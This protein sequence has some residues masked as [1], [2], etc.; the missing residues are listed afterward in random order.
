MAATIS[1]YL[2]Q[3]PGDCRWAVILPGN[4][5]K[6]TALAKA[7]APLLPP[8]DRDRVTSHRLVRVRPLPAGRALVL[9]LGVPAVPPQ[10]VRQW[11]MQT[12]RVGSGLATGDWGRVSWQGH[13]AAD[14]EAVQVDGWGYRNPDWSTGYRA[15]VQELT[16]CRLTGLAVPVTLVAD[17]DL[18]LP[19]RDRLPGKPLEATRQLLV[20][21]S[22]FSTRR[23]PRR[24]RRSRLPTP[25]HDGGPG[26]EPPG[27]SGYGGAIP[28]NRLL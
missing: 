14:G 9:A 23:P 4:R 11:L 18:R 2:A 3:H 25:R 13:T 17:V 27:E 24:S 12:G 16:R 20:P 1:H 6:A 5:A 26:P 8:G 21:W 7:V 19:E 15:V 22:A 10:R 28:R